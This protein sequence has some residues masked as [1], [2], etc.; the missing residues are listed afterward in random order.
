[1]SLEIFITVAASTAFFSGI[2]DMLSRFLKKKK[3]LR[4]TDITI[5]FSNE[6]GIEQSID[7]DLKDKESIHRALELLQLKKGV[8][9]DDS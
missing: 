3:K 5:L 4:E 2:I 8:A 1:M 7:V 6:K 9:D